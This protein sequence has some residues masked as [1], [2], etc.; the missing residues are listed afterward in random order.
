MNASMKRTKGLGRGLDALLGADIAAAPE[1][2]SAAPR[3]LPLARLQP[4]KYQPRTRME[5]EALA[6]LSASIARQGVI[7]PIL[8]RPVQGG[9]YEIIAGERR[10][11]AA[12][13]AGLEEV[14]VVVR[15]V[16]D[17]AALAMA[18]IENIQREDLNP[19][20][21]AQGVQRL[22]A[23]FSFTHEQAAEAIGRSRS[24]TTNLLRLLQLA[25]PVQ[26]LL[27]SGALDMGHARAVLGLGVLEQVALAKEAAER[28]Y[29]VRQ[30]EELARRASAAPK[31]GGAA[32]AAPRK[33]RDLVRLEEQ[34]SDL[35]A[36][37]VVIAPGR[38]ASG[39]ILID[40][41]GLDQLQGILDAIRAR[42][43]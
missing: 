25:P 12:R 41:A 27:M 32:A 22:V 21:E 24:A 10:Y 3:S 9:Q 33:D 8:V 16:A 38:G 26:E 37:R 36:T 17:D 31:A 43:E 6:E 7:Q 13:M 15:E 28:G 2:S 5:P 18:L 30:T 1:A 42:A 23:E 19:L 11:R 14:P 4:G 20:E 35:L 34:L 40:Y 29:S 39:R